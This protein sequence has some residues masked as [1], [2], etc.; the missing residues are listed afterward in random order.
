MLLLLSSGRV[1]VPSE[2]L[3]EREKLEVEVLGTPGDL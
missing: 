2:G 1:T 3:L